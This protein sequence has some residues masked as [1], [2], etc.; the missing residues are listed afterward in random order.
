MTASAVSMKSLGID[1][2]SLEDKLAL[3]EEIWETVCADK[4]AFKL[5]ETQ[6][7]EL[8]RRIADADAHPEDAVPWEE[9]KA[10]LE[11]RLAR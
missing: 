9:V 4:S 1:R 11:A 6:L 3:V 7:T 5:T 2:L 10:S 8:D